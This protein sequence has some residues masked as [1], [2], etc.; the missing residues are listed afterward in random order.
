MDVR[1]SSEFNSGHIESSHNIP[2]QSLDQKIDQL[3]KDKPVVV[4]CAFGG[5]STMAAAKL[6]SMGYRVVDAGSI[7]N[8][9]KQIKM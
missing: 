3:D 7:K 1:S 4:Y 5:R 2:V 8:I 9:R 6:K